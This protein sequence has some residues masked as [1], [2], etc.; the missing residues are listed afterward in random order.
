MKQLFTLVLL[1]TSL[2]VHGQS[3]FQDFENG[4]EP[5]TVYDVD[6]KT[7]NSNV[8][9][10]TEAWTVLNVGFGNGTNVAISTS[11]YEPVGSA[12]DWMVTP[13][14]HLPDSNGI[15]RWDAKAQDA[16][17]RDGYTL[18]IST[19][20]NT[21]ADFTEVVFQTGAE[22]A[23][24]TT[25][26]VDLDAYAGQ[27]VYFAFRNTSND[28]F[29]LLVDNIFVGEQKQRDILLSRVTANITYGTALEGPKSLGITIQNFG[30]EPITSMNAT[31]HFNGDSA[32]DHLSG[33]NIA[34]GAS[35]T[36]THGTP[37]E[38]VVGAGYQVSVT[39]DSI[40]ATVD[41][42]PSNNTYNSPMFKVFPPVPDLVGTSAEG[43]PIHLYESLAQGKAV[44]F[45]FFASWCVP[46]EVSTPILNNLYV[47][48]GAGEEDLDV[49][50]ITIE[51]GDND[52]DVNGLDWGGTYPL[53]SFNI[54]GYETYIHY[55]YNHGLGES[56]IP[57]F[58]MICPNL[59]DLAH[60]EIIEFYTGIDQIQ[61]VFNAWQVSK[62]AC[63][64]SLSSAVKEIT[65]IESALIVPNPAYE[66]FDLQLSLSK[67]TEMS[68]QIIDV[69]GKTVFQE[70]SSVFPAG[71]N[72]RQVDVSTLANGTYFVR[73]LSREGVKT[74][75]LSVVN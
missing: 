49:I 2:Y 50:G 44:I 25:R 9:Y 33:L 48:N 26:L 54:P 34:S 17:F 10:I 15:I 20:G 29:L 65:S 7:V 8:N 36:F 14:I 24:W 19:T 42:D 68:L 41:D 55:S 6:G 27:D 75:K 31:W 39:I 40:N 21:P 46:C 62:D 63:V 67:T 52:A 45:D 3:F 28:K 35:Y 71:E 38:Y 1:A 56:A 66:S 58:V 64:D 23:S 30:V 47:A 37:L 18:Y 61:S 73:L 43:E 32:T 51:S 13:L 5:M 60:S 4:I 16:S 74:I 22:V 59:D 12:D 53:M 70:P 57:F 11:W 69:T 72:V